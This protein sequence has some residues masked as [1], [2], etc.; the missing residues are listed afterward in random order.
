MSRTTFYQCGGYNQAHSFYSQTVTSSEYNNSVECCSI[1]HC[2][3]KSATTTA[4]LLS[5][6]IL[7]MCTGMKI[8]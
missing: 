4:S 3:Y 7:Y 5:K 6:Y 8:L 1:E 2:Y